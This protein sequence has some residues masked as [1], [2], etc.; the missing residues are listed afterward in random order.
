MSDMDERIERAE[1]MRRELRTFPD[2]ELV[3]EL[4]RRGLLKTAAVETRLSAEATALGHDYVAHAKRQMADDLGRFI[5]DKG[6]V[7]TRRADVP[8]G[9]VLHMGVT[10][11]WQDAHLKGQETDSKVE[12]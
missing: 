5:L 11:L 8:G 10:V 1:T 2:T 12:G 3:K 6:A 4:T 9:V 7:T